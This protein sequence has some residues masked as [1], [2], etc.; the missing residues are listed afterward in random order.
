MEKFTVNIERRLLIINEGE[1]LIDAKADLYSGCKRL[2][3]QDETL[4]KLKFPFKVIGGDPIDEERGIYI[5]PYF[6]LIHGWKIKPFEGNHRLRITNGV[7]LTETGECPFV[8]TDGNYNVFVE[9]SQPVKTELAVTRISA[10]T[11]EQNEALFSTYELVELLN[12]YIKNKKYL[13]KENGK[14]YLVI[15]DV[16]D[17]ADILKKELKDIYGAPIEDVRPGLIAIEEKSSV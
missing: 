8:P 3:L 10:L 14:W 1:T 7:L 11:P 16:N 15:R 9:Y 13:K 4:K 2:W 12:A 6:Y 5:T 17:T